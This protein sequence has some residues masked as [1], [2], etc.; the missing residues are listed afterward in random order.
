MAGPP[1][2]KKNVSGVNSP[3]QVNDRPPNTL[4]D[5]EED[6]DQ[7]M[8]TQEEEQQIKEVIS[9]L[10]H[11]AFYGKNLKKS[12]DWVHYQGDDETL[13]NLSPR[14]R[15]ITMVTRMIKSCK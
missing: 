8:I 14:S 2:K 7:I 1:G 13:K 6:Q 11:K 9:D 10:N 15:E 3:K 4:A 5:E 12:K